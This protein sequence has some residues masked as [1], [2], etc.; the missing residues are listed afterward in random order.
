MD[1]FIPQHL[2]NTAWAFATASQHDA[3]LFAAL[4]WAAERFSCAFSTQDPANT[5]WAFTTARSRSVLSDV[6][7]DQTPCTSCL[8]SLETS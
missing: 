5:T 6:A 4:V 7:R 8:V 2:A 3:P 1:N